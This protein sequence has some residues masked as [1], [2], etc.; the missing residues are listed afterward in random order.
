MGGS[1]LIIVYWIKFISE[2][3]KVTTISKR[4]KHKNNKNKIYRAHNKRYPRIPQHKIQLIKTL[5][6]L[7]SLKKNKITKIDNI[8]LIAIRY[9][10]IKVIFHIYSRYI[11]NL[12]PL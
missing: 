5:P 4:Y 2:Y 1:R 3:L 8:Y 9:P 6:N 11:S 10:F 7:I 12:Y